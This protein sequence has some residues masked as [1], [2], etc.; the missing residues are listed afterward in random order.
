MS[1]RAQEMS[2]KVA[3]LTL[4]FLTLS[5]QRI[6]A[7]ETLVATGAEWRYLDDGSDQAT[8]WFMPGFPDDT[9]KTG[10]AKLGWLS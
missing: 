6:D 8:A 4:T 3:A 7:Q 9:W 10:T 5:C 2:F 1:F